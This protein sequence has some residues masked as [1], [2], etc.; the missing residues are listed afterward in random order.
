MTTAL[1]DA[2]EFRTLLEEELGLPIRP[3]DL[4]RPLDDFPDWDS[5]LLL[6]LVTVVENLVGRPIP[7]VDLLE[8]RTFRQ[9]YEVVMGR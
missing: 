4:D 2:E 6:R 7:V 8:T 3:E 1:A 5:V 9:M